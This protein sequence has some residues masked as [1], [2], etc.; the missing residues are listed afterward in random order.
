[1]KFYLKTNDGTYQIEASSEQEAQAKATL[2][3]FYGNFNSR[4][5]ETPSQLACGSYHVSTH[6]GNELFKRYGE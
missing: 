3:S 6:D 2:N 5:F 1:M 4:T